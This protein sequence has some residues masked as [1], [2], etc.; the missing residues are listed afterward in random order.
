MSGY[1]SDVGNIDDMVINTLEILKDEATI[2]RFRLGAL[3]TAMRFDI[4]KVLPEYIS[5]YETLVRNR[6][7][8]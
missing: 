8:V 4:E 1:L 3:N 5:L 7:S 6:A 2:S